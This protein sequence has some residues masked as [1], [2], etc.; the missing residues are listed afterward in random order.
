MAVTF[1]ADKCTV[2][3]IGEDKNSNRHYMI[4]SV[5]LQYTTEEKDLGVWIS[6][7]LKVSFRV[8]KAVSVAN[9]ILGLIRSKFSLTLT[10]S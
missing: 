1:N 5:G 6:N 2:M 8:P 10:A 9:Q 3:H 4:K 7:D